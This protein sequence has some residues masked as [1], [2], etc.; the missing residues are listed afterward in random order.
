MKQFHAAVEVT[1][2]K[3]IKAIMTAP[4]GNGM[5]ALS[6]ENKEIL[7]TMK[8]YLKSGNNLS[9]PH[10]ASA[11]RKKGMLVE[12]VNTSAPSDLGTIAA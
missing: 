4:K 2:N 6:K 11:S 9:W 8:V 7:K 3:R 1:L 10:S 5:K 12:I